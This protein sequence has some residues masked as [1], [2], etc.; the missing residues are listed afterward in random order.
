M[1]FIFTFVYEKLFKPLTL[2]WC[3]FPL[4]LQNLIYEYLIEN[5]LSLSDNIL[6]NI[7]YKSKGK[8]FFSLFLCLVR[9]Y[10]TFFICLNFHYFL[11]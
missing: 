1:N 4:E 2:D 7:K 8:H 5:E 6:G 3:I 11:K 10:F 9:V